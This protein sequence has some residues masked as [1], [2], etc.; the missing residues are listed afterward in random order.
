MGNGRKLKWDGGKIQWNKQ[1]RK[2][3]K[4]ELNEIGKAKQQETAK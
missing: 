4:M 3:E 1:A 2:I